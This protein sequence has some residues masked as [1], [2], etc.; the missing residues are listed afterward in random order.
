MTA[1]SLLDRVLGPDGINILFQPIYEVQ[2]RTCRL[3]AVEAL[4][5]G[6][7][8]TNLEPAAVLF[9]YARRKHEGALV[10]RT[11]VTRA[12]H[13]AAELPD[14]PRI[15]LNVNAPTLDRDRGFVQH[16]AETAAESGISPGRLVV[17]IVEHAPFW[18]GPTFARSLVELR[19]LG[20]R[21]ALDD[22]G[23]GHSNYR[24]I[25]E[26]RP[27]YLKIDAY[28]VRHCARDYYR[29]CVLRSITD[30]AASFCARAVAEG[31]ESVADLDMALALGLDLMQ[32][33]LLCAPLPAELLASSAPLTRLTLPPDRTSAIAAA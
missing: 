15:C 25:L 26:C 9:E 13:A 10:D 16:L 31:L 2:D 17:E 11:C 24:M 29:R 4:A 7:R 14:L 1:P 21:I 20:V 30:L 18:D 5:R 27:D 8:G 23:L 33:Y 32:G 28:L 22:V 12:L 19:A 6:P 3:H